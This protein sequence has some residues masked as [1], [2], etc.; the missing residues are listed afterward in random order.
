MR[1][2]LEFAVDLDA[3]IEEAV[4]LSGSQIPAV[5]DRFLQ[6]GL[7]K[8]RINPVHLIRLVDALLKSLEL[9]EC[10]ALDGGLRAVLR[11]ELSAEDGGGFRRE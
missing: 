10:E 3:F 2:V 9:D 4:A 8:E 5:L 1:R 11:G 7:T 6:P